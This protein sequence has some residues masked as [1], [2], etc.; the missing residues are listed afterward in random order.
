M[1]AAIGVPQ[2]SD[3]CGLPAI[4]TGEEFVVPAAFGLPAPFEG[5]PFSVLS[6]GGKPPALG[7]VVAGSLL[8]L[9][10]ELFIIL[11]GQYCISPGPGQKSATNPFP[12]METV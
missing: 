6:G 9:I 2:L 5:R 11:L 7:D 10:L 4:P 1:Q 12:Q 3:G 8:P